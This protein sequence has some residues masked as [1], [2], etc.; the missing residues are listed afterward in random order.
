M[1]A[2]V[3]FESMFGNTEVIARAIGEGLGERFDV[4]VVEVGSAPDR[5]PDDVG[6]LV[7]GGPTHAFGMTRASTREDAV[8]QAGPDGVVSRGRGLREW[9]DGLQPS[10]G[11]PAATFDTHIDKPFPGSASG[12]ARRKLRA[13]G[14]DV[15]G[16]ESFHV[17]DTRGPLADGETAR[18]RAWGA[19]LA[20]RLVIA[21]G[22]S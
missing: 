8:K 22:G 4:S 3:V 10:P 16:A 5:L 21:R 1:R 9:L 11:L 7:A 13:H 14:F 12:S 15:R 20:G 19:Q 6:M 2:L 17:V 18:A